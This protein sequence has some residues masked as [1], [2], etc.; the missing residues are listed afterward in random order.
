VRGVLTPMEV[1]HIK[2]MS[3]KENKSLREIE[4]FTQIIPLSRKKGTRET[5][6]ENHYHEEVYQNKMM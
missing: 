4:Y 3:E 2:H 1:Y 5:E 6:K